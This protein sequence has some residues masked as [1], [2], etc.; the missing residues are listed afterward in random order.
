MGL[1]RSPNCFSR[2]RLHFVGTDY[3][4]ATKAVESVI[5]I[6]RQYG[7]EDFV[8]EQTGRIPYFDALALLQK[9]DFLL[10]PGSD[11]PRYTASKIVPYLYAAKPLLA[12]FNVNSPVVALL[13]KFRC[14]GLIS[15]DSKKSDKKCAKQLLDVWEQLLFCRDDLNTIDPSSLKSFFPET[16]AEKQCRLFDEVQSRKAPRRPNGEAAA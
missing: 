14:G 15:F 2:L 3:A 8:S 4:P 6:A 12:V 9:S 16:M 7:V 1:R 13:E 10:V 11:D 5:P